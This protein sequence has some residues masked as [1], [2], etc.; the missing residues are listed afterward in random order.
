MFERERR[1]GEGW[2]LRR[3]C[4]LIDEMGDSKRMCGYVRRE[5][6]MSWGVEEVV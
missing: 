2:G 5:L 3:D 1:C 6:R 4:C